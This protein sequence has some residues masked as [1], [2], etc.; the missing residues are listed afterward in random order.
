[1][2]LPEVLNIGAGRGMTGLTEGDLDQR[3]RPAEVQVGFDVYSR[4]H[5]A[6][7]RDRTILRVGSHKH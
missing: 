4:F 7:A 5:V 6:F 3:V 2:W 1:M